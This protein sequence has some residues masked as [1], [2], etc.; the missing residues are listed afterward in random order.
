M[1][2]TSL[3]A[4]LAAGCI[5]R[6]Y[7]QSINRHRLP[8]PPGPKPKPLIGNALDI[9]TQAGWLTYTEWAETYKSDILHVEALGQHIV[10]LNSYKDVVEIMEKRASN[11]SSHPSIPMLELMDWSG[12]TSLLPY[13]DLWRRHRRVLEQSF[14]KDA[15]AQYEAIQ[16]SKTHQMLKSL[17]EDPANL[18]THTRIAAIATI[19]A[20]LYG[21]NISSLDDEFVC[22]AEEALDGGAKAVLPGAAL[23]NIFPA[24]RHIPPWL[25]G[26]GFHQI[27]RRVKAL[28][29]GM[30]NAAFD[31]V[32][33]NMKD[34]TGE[35]S[36]L[37]T[38]LEASDAEG[39][40][41]EYEDILKRA[42]ATAHVGAAE[43]TANAVAT[44][45]L[46]M[47]INP[48]AQRKAQ[49]EIDSVIDNDHLPELRDRPSLPYVEALY[50]EVMRWHPGLPLGSPHVSSD[51]DVYKGFLIPRGSIIFTNIW[52][53]TRDESIYKDPDSFQPERYFEDGELNNDNTVLAFGFGKRCH[54]ASSSV[55]LAIINVL[56]T[57][58]IGKAKDSQG[59]DV[60]IEGKHT[61]DAI[62]THPCPFPC[63]VTLRSSKSRGLIDSDLEE[64]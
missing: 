60:E 31:V 13:G 25:P 44:F 21:H 47:A 49:D 7:L 10:I 14:K 40:S 33:K 4:V 38:L 15:A 16:T 1:D 54:L 64:W 52:A 32:R 37:R 46:A 28:T 41:A 57:L 22:I 42:F 36:L 34:G 55:W 11:Y 61:T 18:Y 3:L 2:S 29:Y 19:M 12:F 39:G 45:L 24:L 9:P 51:D 23:V 17:L 35:P 27:A 26:G 30:K 8:L 5:F 43:T 56:A 58:N 62:A 59:H 48:N 6:R 63:S 53:M 50:R 20:I